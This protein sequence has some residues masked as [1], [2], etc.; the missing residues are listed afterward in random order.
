MGNEENEKERTR[1][2]IETNE[3]VH[4][5]NRGK[6]RKVMLITELP[7]EFIDSRDISSLICLWTWFWLIRIP[8]YDS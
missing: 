3:G 7:R 1:K 8:D 2:V 6:E 5:E 4:K